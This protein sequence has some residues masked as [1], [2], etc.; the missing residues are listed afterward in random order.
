MNEKEMALL[1]H[2]T[3]KNHIGAMALKDG[4]ER[5]GY[6]NLYLKMKEERSNAVTIFRK[7]RNA[8]KD[9]Y[10]LLGKKGRFGE[11]R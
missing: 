1:V 6:K 7:L 10:K 11:V 8:E 3:M 4:E 9:L 2:Y 5:E